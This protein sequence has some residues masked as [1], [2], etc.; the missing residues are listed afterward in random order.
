[1]PVHLSMTSQFPY[2]QIDD[3]GEH[4]VSLFNEV[5]RGHSFSLTVQQK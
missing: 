3:E 1:L 5:I 4:T 2:K